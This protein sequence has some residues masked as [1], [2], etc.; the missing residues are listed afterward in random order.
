MEMR[1]AAERVL[2]AETLEEKLCLPPVEASDESPGRAIAVPGSGPGRPANLKMC[3]EGVQVK[4]P[5]THHLDRER[6]RGVMMHF[7]ANHE[8]LAAELMALVLLKFPDAPK[9][10]RAGVYEAMREEQMHTLMYVRRMRECGIEFGELPLNDYFW[11]LVAP[12]E[13]PMDFVVRLNLTFEQA[14]LDFSKHYA[15]LFRQVGDDSTAAVLE[16]IYQDEIG[17]VGHGVKWFRRWKKAGSSDW[18]AF[19]EALELPFSPVRAKGIAP[20]NAEGRRE[21]GFDDEFIRH[22]EVFG[23][24]R[25]RTPVLAWFNPDAESEV[26][27]ARAGRTREPNAKVRAMEE[28][29]EILA[30][31]WCHED[32]LALLRKVPATDHLAKLQAAGLKIPEL[33]AADEIA[34]LTERKLGGFRPWAW[35]P[36]AAEMLRELRERASKSSAWPWR[37]ALPEEW[38]SKELGWKLSRQLEPAGGQGSLCRDSEDAVAALQGGLADGPMLLKAA[39]ACA[40]RGHLR[41]MPGNLQEKTRSWIEAAVAEHGCVLVE[42]WLERV[43]DFSTLY[44][45]DGSGGFK[46]HGMTVMENDDTGRFRGTRVAPKWGSLLEPDVARF[47][48]GEEAVQRLYGERLPAALVGLLPG[49]SGP[50]GV[51]AMVHRGSDGSLALRPVVEVNARMTMGRVAH[52]LWKKFGRPPEGRLKILRKREWGEEESGLPLND[53]AAAREFVA[54]WQ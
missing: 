33:I 41:V 34:E 9:S 48:F 43:L 24:S 44:D 47:L 23:Q 54:V 37:K 11:R 21:A 5:G 10:Y 4:F 7:L 12:V 22:L 50:V 14:N 49:Y 26:L 38:L 20:F 27:A 29:L 15:A 45:L 18:R 53:P 2:R 8:L 40:G 39:H 31:A 30:L 1:E 17:H 3:P 46:F 28:D 25:G 52:E 16:K 42:P 32:D 36:E 6:E 13:S 51:D 19:C 35:S